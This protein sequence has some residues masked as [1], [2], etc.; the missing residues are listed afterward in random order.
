M[1]GSQQVVSKGDFARICNVSPGRVTQWIAEGKI[2]ADALVGDGRAA[3][4]IVGIAQR[5]VRARTDSGQAFGNGLGTR[6]DPTSRPA[7]EPRRAASTTVPDDE[8]ADDALADPIDKQIKREK[9]EA[10][11]RTNR[12]AAADEAAKQ[13]FYTAAAE[14]RR[15]MTA[16][17]A[18][19]LRTFEGAIPDLADKFAARF[20]VEGRDVNLFLVEFF[21]DIRDEAAKKAQAT[22]EKMQA[23]A[24]GGQ[25]ED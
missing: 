18:Q 10:L 8:D 13:G 6:L 23:S 1:T 11:Q 24:P 16:V 21:R 4:I 12:I 3:K 9:L 15:Q 7:P 5:Q 20:K 14:A 17:A 25:E 22:A 2:T 19:V